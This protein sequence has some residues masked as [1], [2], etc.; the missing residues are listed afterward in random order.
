[1]KNIIVITVKLLVITIVAAALLG[2]V[3][4]ITKEP[5]AEQAR[6]EADEARR[7]AFPDAVSFEALTADIPEAYAII[8]SVYTAKDAEGNTIGITAGVVTKGY[9]SGL[10]LTVGI[11]ADGAIKGVIVGSHNETPGLGAKAAE[12]WFESQYTAK[13]YGQPLTVVKSP[14]AADSEIQAITSATITSRGVT[15]AV[16]TVAAYYTDI[17]GGAQ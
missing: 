7:A 9:S 12:D 6:K 10:S 5:I 16:N 11:G 15:D 1:M 14:P 17:L 4:G 13:P 8:Q 2:V 3:N